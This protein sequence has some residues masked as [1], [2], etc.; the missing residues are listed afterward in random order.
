MAHSKMSPKRKVNVRGQK[1]SLAYINDREKRMLRKAGG[2]GKPGPSGVPTYFDVGEGLGGYD[3]KTEGAADTAGGRGDPDAGIGGGGMGGGGFSDG[4]EPD[5]GKDK[6]GSGVGRQDGPGGSQEEQ[7][8]KSSG[9]ITGPDAA[10]LYTDKQ[11]NKLA[12]D[13][14]ARKDPFTGIMKYSPVGAIAN[15][16]AK[17]TRGRIEKELRAG[18]TPIFNK[19]REIMGV[20]HDGPFGLGQV[21]TGRTMDKDQYDGPAEFANQVTMDVS[22]DGGDNNVRAGAKKKILPKDVIGGEMPDAPKS[23]EGGDATEDAKRRSKMGKESTISTTAQGL[24]GSAKTR[25][26]SLMSGLIS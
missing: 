7:S 26:R 25:N 20:M 11:K 8:Y 24:L 21:Y 3:S 22:D 12:D 15:Q 2:S 4:N 14:A 13:V 23:G 18:G 5:A 17:F 16:I 19:D 9:S 6:G 1:H 10:S